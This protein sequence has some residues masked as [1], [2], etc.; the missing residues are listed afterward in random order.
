MIFAVLPY[1]FSTF[2]DFIVYGVSTKIITLS[3]FP[4]STR[5]KLSTRLLDAVPRLMNFFK[6]FK[7]CK[8]N[9]LTK[10]YHYETRGFAQELKH[11]MRTNN[12]DS[13]Q[14]FSSKHDNLYTYIKH[15][16]II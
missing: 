3:F 11:K 12:E 6:Y 15:L 5:S 2:A 10:K 7:N 13:L 16:S 8:L 1:I 9:Y 4:L 14:I